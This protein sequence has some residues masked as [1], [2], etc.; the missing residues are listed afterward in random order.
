MIH[1]RAV[2]WGGL[3][4]LG[5][6]CDLA[7]EL[8]LPDASPAIVGAVE[9]VALGGGVT[10]VPLG[11]TFAPLAVEPGDFDGDGHMDVLV[12][13]VNAS[14][15]AVGAVLRGTGDGT[16]QAPIHAGLAGCSAYPVVGD[17]DGN[18]RADAVVLGCGAAELAVYAG[19]PNGALAPWPGWPSVDFGIGAVQAT[20]VAD[21][22]GD[23]DG[24]VLT[25]RL[26]GPQGVA[27]VD[28][29]LGNGGFGIWSF[30]T[31]VIGDPDFT[32]FL[33]TQILGARLD[34]DGLLDLVLTDRDHDVARLL[35]V[36]PATFGFP[37][38]LGV[39]VSPWLTRVGDLDGDGLDELV[40]V[41]RSDRAIQVL[42]ATGGGGL[43]AQAP[44]S[45]GGYEPYD[46]ALA[47]VNGDGD[48]DVALVG[49]TLRRLRW[50]PGDGA[51]GFGAHQDVALPSGAVRVH[52]IDL[53]GDAAHELVA[54]TLANGSLSL[55][56]LTRP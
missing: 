51:G 35:G 26:N 25:F 12:A 7:G 19:Q 5:A 44:V 30:T 34:D 16:F 31:T 9:P 22:E 24:D 20:V 13:G 49:N 38:Q 27:V 40:V 55:V 6:G 50:L 14:A 53:D 56:D 39:D 32:G 17:I 29:T 8:D 48:L 18:A 37:L 21:Y 54:G 15:A 41:S 11:L 2:A 52:G 3:A 46:A 42:L 23:G 45:L 47:D 43:A 33:P 28:L 1:A 10:T 36:P 4:A